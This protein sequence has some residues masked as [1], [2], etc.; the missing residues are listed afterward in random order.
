MKPVS[1]KQPSREK[2]SI[3]WDDGVV[4]T[5]SVK[6]LRDQ[7]PCAGCKGE[8]VLFK[9][10]VPPEPDTSA[11]GRYEIKTITPVGNYAV[12]IGW[13]DGHDTGI[14]PWDLLRSIG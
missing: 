3:Q 7:C 11:P 10:Y 12:K 14:Y 1:I 8:T 9:S 5:I 13:R 2:I 4:S 6:E